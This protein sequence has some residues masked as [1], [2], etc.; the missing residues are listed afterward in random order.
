MTSV[1]IVGE[2]RVVEI[3]ARLAA[4]HD[5]R[6]VA[7]AVLVC[8]CAALCAFRVYSRIRRSRGVVRASWLMLIGLGAGTGVWSTHFIGMLAFE[9]GVRVGYMLEASVISLFVS[10]ALTS[11]A[12]ALASAN[13]RW[14][15]LLLGGLMFGVADATTFY[16]G[17]AALRPAGT[18]AWSAPM[19]ALSLLAAL[20]IPVGALFAASRARTWR[21]QAIGAGLLTLGVCL[22]H[23]AGMGAIP[24]CPTW[25]SAS[26]R[27]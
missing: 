22:T 26:R 23:L 1:I 5:Y 15:D 11:C 19:V 14:I 9:P 3:L 2:K 25:P 17:I 24:S 6:F 4:E 10:V 27:R 20:G 16:S 7:L 12:F 18:L 8:A 21:Q 13:R